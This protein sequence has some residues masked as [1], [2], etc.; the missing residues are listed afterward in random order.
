[1]S[2]AKLLALGI[3]AGMVVSYDEVR[4]ALSSVI[5]SF[6]NCIGGHTRPCPSW[7]PDWST[8]FSVSLGLRYV[9][10][11]CADDLAPIDRL[12]D[13]KQTLPAD[14]SPPIRYPAIRPWLAGIECNSIN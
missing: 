3:H 14:Y 6:L 10:E 13:P 7:S 9:L 5:F 2:L 8:R 1:M 12:I 11:S 4:H